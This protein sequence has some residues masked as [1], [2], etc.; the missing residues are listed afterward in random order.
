MEKEILS[1]TS[2]SISAFINH[3]QKSR[4]LLTAFEL[5]IFTV[6]DNRPLTFQEVSQIIKTDARATDRL[7]NAVCSI[8]FLKKINGKFQNTE[9]SSKYFVKSKHGYMAGLGHSIS[10]WDTSDN[11]Y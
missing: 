4:I 5:E 3:F 1:N 11:P 9:D 10:L 7:M 6:L 8:G 2:E